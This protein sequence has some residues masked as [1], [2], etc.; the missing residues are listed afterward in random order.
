MTEN[1]KEDNSNESSTFH[2][3]AFFALAI[4]A[5]LITVAHF[6]WER[7]ARINDPITNYN[8]AYEDSSAL[9]IV[10]FDAEHYPLDTERKDSIT[11]SEHLQNSTT[12]LDSVIIVSESFNS[13]L[14]KLKDECDVSELYITSKTPAIKL[15]NLHEKLAEACPELHK[16]SREKNQAKIDKKMSRLDTLAE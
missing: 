9:S 6:I 13:R 10:G 12:H 14:K 8:V 2:V 5:I 16:T 1:L 7:N 15:N 11:I 3:L 4:V